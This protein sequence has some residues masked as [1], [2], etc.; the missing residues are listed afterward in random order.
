VIVS[1]D[2]TK[3]QIRRLLTAGAT[4][5]LTKPIDVRELLGIIDV[6]RLASRRDSDKLARDLR[7]IYTTVYEADAARCLDEFH[8]IWGNRYPA[9]KT[10]WSN[11]CEFVPFLDCSPESRRATAPR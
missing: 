8:T 2:A 11:A 9:V 5:Y 6:V 1:A 7:P 3:G 10:L 4:A